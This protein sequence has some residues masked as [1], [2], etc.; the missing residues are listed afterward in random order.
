MAKTCT[1][2]AYA[3]LD[4]YTDSGVV[5]WAIEKIWG[6]GDSVGSP[7][8]VFTTSED[9]GWVRDMSVSFDG[10]ES[11]RSGAIGNSKESIHETKVF[12]KGTV[13]FQWKA[14]TEDSGGYFD[15]DH[16]EFHAGDK[17]YYVDAESGWVEVSHTFTTDGEHTLKWIYVKDAYESE[18]SD[19][20]WMD[21]FIWTPVPQFTETQTTL[22]AVPFAWLQEKY[23]SIT[24]AAAF[25][26][27]ANEVAANGVN[28][29]WE[30]YVAGIDPTDSTAKF[31]TKIEMVDG[32]PVITWE[33]DM[34]E[35]SGKI[36]A[37][38][39]K[40]LGSI[41][42]KTWSEVADDAEANF[43]FFKVEV[44]IP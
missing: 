32:K 38:A 23:P 6:V 39:Y 13:T 40:L 15:W 22:V 37:R 1:I 30:C 21:A 26:A 25:E 7:D 4:D 20:I 27:K 12:G 28:K 34:N 9:L 8:Q 16:G 42:L 3:I 10:S 43:N 35:G 33:P 11:M 29:V 17:V 19:C 41:D 31:V 14:S 5:S 36:G 18:G 24:D 2:K 44:S